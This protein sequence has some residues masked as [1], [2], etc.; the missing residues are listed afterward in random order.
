MTINMPSLSKTTAEGIL[1][2]LTTTGLA[3]LASGS[4]L[5]GP[6]VTMWLTLGMAVL[7]AWTR[8]AQKDATT[9]TSTDVAKANL[10]AQAKGK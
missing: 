10:A 1:S 8:L 3:L 7:T 6:K 5:V 9:I 2:L 4:P